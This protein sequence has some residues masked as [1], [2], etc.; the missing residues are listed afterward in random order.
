MTTHMLYALIILIF[1]IILFITE[2]LRV[3][4]VALSVVVALM[5]TGLLTT[6]EALA[7]FSNSAVLTIV[8]LFVVGGALMQTGLAGAIGRRILVIAGTSETRLIAVIMIS[9]AI[10]SGFMSNTGTVAVLLPAIISLA[11][12][13]KTS[14]AKLLIPLAFGGSLGGAATLIGTPPNL[15]VSD[16][17]REQDLSPF[18]FF[19][20]TPVGAILIVTGTAFM[21]L[22]A[23][24]LLPDNQ[25]KSEVQRV[26]TPEELLA[27]YKLPDNLFRLRVRRESELVG[28]SIAAA[29]LSQD[30]Q[31]MVLGILPAPAAK[32]LVKLGKQ[33]FVLQSETVEPI[34]PH[35]ETVIGAHD[36]LVVRGA[37]NDIAHAAA[38][39]N[40]GVQP[41]Q[42]ED[43]HTLISQEVGIAEVLLPPRSS[44]VGKT[45]VE[46]R[47]G[48][49]Y[50]LTV[51]GINRPGVDE[52]LELKT[53]ELRFGDTLLVQGSWQDILALRKKRRDF[54]VTGHP[55]AMLGAPARRKA[56]I[57][58]AVMLGMLILAVTNVVSIATA[59][60]LAALV[61]VLTGC[62]SMDEA[63]ETVD[64]KSV[65]LIAGMLPMSTALEKVG[66]V[67]LVAHGLT[68]ALG[69]YG[70]LAVMGG[71]F[72]LTAIFTQFLSNT[73]TAV[74]VAP[75]ALAT[76]QKLGVQPHA[77][78]MAVAV[79][80]SMAFVTPVA[81]PTN[82][83][84]MGAG[85]YRFSDYA[86]VGVPMLVV[87][88]LITIV[89][90]PILWPL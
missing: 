90:L 82:T 60:M 58:L 75:I 32:Q 34:V 1:A 35:A 24:Y 30:F 78:L 81:S 74:L 7:G 63:Y 46:T 48:T 17:L 37:T 15:I 88:M 85:N 2:W 61:I 49:L 3:D 53:T 83:L 25:P 36:I 47:F 9:V 64:W 42:A 66:I 86:R 40:L 45:L 79:A 29:Q 13:A 62:L 73:A 80:T 57:A 51:L 39:W 44:L 54:V 89:V 28:K 84:V 14:P 8:A 10:L 71:I 23:R 16:L 69:S 38:Y 21:L 77:F 43:E 41:A 4:V 31:V 11:R 65:V 87:M 22:V 50:K 26:E 67:N 33:R 19:D 27:L 59:S 52:Q 55:E 68:S 20:Y 72:L 5:L 12:S 18:G 76:A 6:Q 56:P 70:P